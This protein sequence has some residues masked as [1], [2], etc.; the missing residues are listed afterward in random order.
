MAD[1]DKQIKGI[2]NTVRSTINPD[3][4]IPKDKENE[5][6]NVRIKRMKAVSYTHLT[7]PTIL[8]V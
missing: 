5:P 2:F 6:M 1:F 3:Y 4:A 7:L 8:L